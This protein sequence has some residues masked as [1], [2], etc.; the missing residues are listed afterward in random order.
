MKIN[1]KIHNS[2]TREEARKYAI[3]WQLWAS[4]QSLSYLELAEWAEHFETIGKKFDLT[5]EFKENGL[6]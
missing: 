6:I 2:Y 5:E 3:D 4:E 1:K